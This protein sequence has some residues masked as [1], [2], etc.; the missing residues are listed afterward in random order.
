MVPHSLAVEEEVRAPLP[1][2]TERLMSPVPTYHRPLIPPPQ[3]SNPF[4]DFH[5]EASSD[6]GAVRA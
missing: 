3:L 6:G 1:V 4:R 2:R 5:G